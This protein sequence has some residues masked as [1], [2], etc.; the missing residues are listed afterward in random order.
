MGYCQDNLHSEQHQSRA[1]PDQTTSKMTLSTDTS[2]LTSSNVVKS[3]PTPTTNQNSDNLNKLEIKSEPLGNSNLNYND[4]SD[5]IQMKNAEIK[6]IYNEE[7]NGNIDNKLEID[8][9][10]IIKKVLEV[11]LDQIKPKSNLALEVNAPGFGLSP[12]DYNLLKSVGK[13]GEW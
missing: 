7:N 5:Y 13:G 1:S 9:E 2:D 8:T 3:T 11:T 6:N 12:D 4:K 10:K